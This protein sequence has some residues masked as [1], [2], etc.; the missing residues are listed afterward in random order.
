MAFTKEEIIKRAK[1]WILP[2]YEEDCINEIKDLLEKNNIDELTERFGADLDFGTGGMRG[3]IRYGTNGMNKYIVAKATQGLANYVNKMIENNPKA[4]IAYDSR[5]FSKEFAI[6]A[7]IVLASN[8][9]KTYIFKEL[10]PTPELSFAVRYLKCST[11]IVI[12]ASHNPKEYNGYK[13]Y[14]NDGGQVISPHDKGIIEEVRKVAKIHDV[15]RKNL[16]ELEKEGMIEWISDEVDKAFINEVIKLSINKDIGKNSDVKIVYTPLHGT[17]A[18]L[19]PEVL[20]L[21][22][23]KNIY[24][25]EKQMNPD[26]EFSTVESPNPEE[27]VA[28]K[29]G[30]EILKEKDADILIA[31][32]PDADRVGI[33]LLDKDKNPV[34]I[35]GNRIGAILEYYILTEK[36]RRGELK[37][38]DAIVKTIVTTNLQDEIAESFGLKVFNMLTGF[39]YIAQK[40][41]NFEEDKDYNY[42]FGG[43]ESYGYLVG[44]HAR[45]KDAI[46]ATLLIAECYA[47]LKSQN[48]TMLDYLEEIFKKYGYYEE[49][50][51]SITIKGLA[52]IAKIGEIMENFRKEPLK[53]LSGI[54]VKNIVDYNVDNVY[55]AKDSKYLLP[56]S[57]VIQYFMEDGSK[58][59]L[60]P[61]GT[62][63][64]IKIYFSTKGN[65]KEEATKKVELYKNALIPMIEKM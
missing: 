26:P 49:Y 35:N 57:N 54:K 14:W 62:E 58:I 16:K 23:Y 15:K 9:I 56:K 59:T 1:E 32:D 25:V 12:T 17:G 5:K 21:M 55:D 61:S 10:R 42:I 40:I 34:I 8:G 24:F 44:T 20:K 50:T 30:I 19:V 18:T 11:G 37:S 60:R 6:E 63:P 53:E 7:A 2:P 52:G 4:V 47:Y 41:R 28:L 45:D 36:K 43:E 46:S 29:M 51:K 33:A 38:N 22:G 27:E 64:K 48:I 39:K 31:T 3:I 13:V 65:S